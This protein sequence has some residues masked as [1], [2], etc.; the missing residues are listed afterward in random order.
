MNTAALAEAPAPDTQAV[1]PRAPRR[2]VLALTRVESVRL[3]RHPLTAA[4]ILFLVGIW[5][6]GWFTNQANQ[7][8]VL[9]DVDRDSELGMMLLVGGAAL[10][11]S[12]L[13]VLRPHRDGTTSLGQILILPERSRTIAHLL[14][15]LPLALLGAA[16]VVARIGVLAVGTPAAGHP[17]P[18]E[19]ATAPVMVL[20]LGALG[21]LLGRLT[22]S[23]IA[24]PLALLA[25]LALL[26]V[27]PLLTNGG[28]AQ[29]LQLVVP[30]GDQAFPLPAPAYLMARPAA[31]H[32]AYLLGLAGLF[33][34]GALVRAGARGA[35]TTVAGLVA[36]ACAAAGAVVQLTPPGA[37]VTAART[38]AMN[39]PSEHQTCRQL[40]HVNYCAFADFTGWIPAWNTVAQAVLARVPATARPA[41]LTVRQRIIVLGS[42][43]EIAPDRV[44]A[45]WQADDAAAG[46]RGAVTVGTRWG[47]SRSAAAF[48]AFVGYRLVTAGRGSD[49]LVCGGAGVLVVWLAGQAGVQAGTGLHKFVSDQHGDTHG[50]SLQVGQVIPG[51]DIAQPEL[52]VGLAA[53]DRPAAD[54]GARVQQSWATLT[55]PGTTAA[56][57]AQLLGVPAPATATTGADS[58]GQCR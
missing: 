5:V 53:L 16:L 51:V 45:A 32:L 56:Q 31:A 14:A 23:A 43:A 25:L 3:L 49:T 34:T 36:V 50:V 28:S 33:A 21:V 19:L 55:A 44:L 40:D 26:V 46:T 2:A 20:L 37:A 38:A 29:W 7:Y 47:D 41:Q 13:A 17:N 39:H 18:F 12:N 8:P 52:A 58:R 54:I 4:A 42:N 10:I 35:R 1:D 11:A 57:A 48:A 22:R 6:S 27:L 9:Q 30:Q 24:A 15:L